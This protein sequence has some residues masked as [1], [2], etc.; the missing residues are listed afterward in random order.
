MRA[1]APDLTR[2]ELA[3]WTSV[4]RK[5]PLLFKR[6]QPSNAGVSSNPKQRSD[7][8]G[9]HAVRSPG[10]RGFDGSGPL[11]MLAGRACSPLRFSH[12]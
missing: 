2:R 4:L 3:T 7:G 10:P 9:L 6:E 11:A 1:R 5:L 12:T 8:R